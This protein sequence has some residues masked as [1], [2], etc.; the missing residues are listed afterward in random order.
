MQKNM[1]RKSFL[2]GAGT[3]AAAAVAGG[4]AA[5][6]A[7]DAKAAAPAAEGNIITRETLEQG[8]DRKSVV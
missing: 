1:S 6:L 2:A 5:A 4:A 8:T 7:D 3:V